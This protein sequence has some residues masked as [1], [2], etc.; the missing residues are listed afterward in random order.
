MQLKGAA[1]ARALAQPDPAIRLYVLGGPDE[2]G[3]RAM[4]ADFAKAMGADADRVDFT[5]ARL[6]E[7]PALLSDEAAAIGLFGGRRWISVTLFS[8]GGDDVLAA[9]EALLDAP[10]AG[11]AAIVVGAGITGKSKLAKLAEKHPAAMLAIS[12]PPEGQDAARIADAIAAP[13]GLKLGRGVASAVIDATGGDRGLIAR[14]IEKLALYCDADPAAPAT[15]ELDHWH[16]IGADLPE[17]D[18]G[19]AVNIILGGQLGAL[20][21]LFATLEATGSADIRLLR[22]LVRRA[23]ELLQL[24]VHVDGGRAPGQVIESHGRGI[25][26]K[27]KSHVTRQLGL[28]DASKVARLIERLHGLEREL[29]TSDNAGTLLLRAG[30]LDITRVAAS[31]AR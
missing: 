9:C 5:P 17:E 15:A 10:A 1:A 7:D 26:W 21:A 3:S 30:L 2:S 6:K 25:F 31:A 24:R 14:E 19:E 20:P 18:L 23:I 16:A 11:N 22:A 4:M 27:E 29:K 28:W 13:L 8:G 12:Y